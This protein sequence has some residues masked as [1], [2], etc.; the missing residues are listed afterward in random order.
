MNTV[1]ATTCSRY[2]KG[3]AQGVHSLLR[4][5]QLEGLLHKYCSSPGPGPHCGSQNNG[6]RFFW[7]S[8]VRYTCLTKQTICVLKAI[9]LHPCR[10]SAK[11]HLK[12]VLRAIIETLVSNRSTLK[13]ATEVCGAAPWK[14]LSATGRLSEYSGALGL[15]HCCTLTVGSLCHT[16]QTKGCQI[17]A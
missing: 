17:V 6:G 13:W 10:G 15:L 7:L 11:K 2:T 12:A 9:S 8:E 4:L 1:T 5:N 3:N 14:E 16:L